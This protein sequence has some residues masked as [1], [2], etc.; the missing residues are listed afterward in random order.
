MVNSVKKLVGSLSDSPRISPVLYRIILVMPSKLHA[1]PLGTRIEVLWRISYDEKGDNEPVDRWWGAVIQ[2]CTKQLVGEQSEAEYADYPIHILLYDAYGEFEED[3]A[4]VAFLPNSMLL[5]LAQTDGPHNGM[6]DWR[7]EGSE[8]NATNAGEAPQQLSLS[9]YAA[10]QA[11]LV[12]QAGLS[13]DADL[14]V[15]SQMPADLQ[16]HMS[17]GYRQFADGVKKMLF[18]LME[19]K[20]TGYVVTEQDVQMIFTRLRAAKEQGSTNVI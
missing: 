12:E 14:E 10:E 9:Q 19:R 2:D 16:L 6:L 17:A 18:E 5:D 8:D 13:S 7:V 1:P 20:P 4:R 3:T 11:A 15:L